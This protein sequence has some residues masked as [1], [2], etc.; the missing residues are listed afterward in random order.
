M[1]PANDSAT[2][3]S[4]DEVAGEW[5]VRLACGTLSSEEQS[6][7]ETWLEACPENGVAYDRA[8]GVWHGLHAIGEAPELIAQ[9]ADALGALREANLKRWNLPE[10]GRRAW[11]SGLVASLLIILAGGWLYL[12]TNVQEFATGRGERQ[13]MMLADGSRL[14]LDALTAVEVAYGGERRAL[15]LVKGRARFDVEHDPARPF[16]VTAAGQTVVATGTSFSVE[17]LNGRLHVIVYEGQ[18]KVLGGPT[19]EA[20]VRAVL[21]APTD[22]PTGSIGPGRELVIVLAGGGQTI[23]DAGGGSLS[24]EG[25]Q[26]EF[27]DEPLAAAVERINRYSGD[28]V[29]IADPRIGALQINGVFNAGDTDAFVEAVATAYG[30][31][32]RR[33]G[34][35]VVIQSEPR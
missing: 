1:K 19:D 2:A 13:A 15:T 8:L 24:W 22:E 28:N 31:R 34:R 14:S 4:R 11:L 7:F 27:V 16:T 35:D 30:L 5:C 26:V 6:A 12:D 29:S 18:V 9:R 33:T 25:G 10:V 23:R 32:I 17:I 20:R 21:A 3:S